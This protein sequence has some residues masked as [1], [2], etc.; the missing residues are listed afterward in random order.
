M[1]KYKT[2]LIT[3]ASSG[4]GE[5]FADALAKQGLDLILVARSKDKLDEIAARLA[6]T[7][8]RRVE[9]IAADLGQPQP[10]AALAKK[11][12]ALG[13][14]VDLLVNNAGF[15]LAGNFHKNDAARH[16][17]MVALNIGAVLDLAQ[18]FL[19]AMLE[20]GA[21]AIINVASL[22]GFQ[23][24]PYMT[25]YGATKAFVLSF[26]EGL[27]AEY[28]GKGICV[29]A[30]CPGPVDTAFF[31]ATGKGESLRK[32]VP[33]GTMLTAEQVVA[34]SLK[35]LAQGKSFVVPGALMKLASLFPRLL[36]RAAV[37]SVAART[38]KH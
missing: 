13:L 26:S 17:Q 35:A 16:T 5:T 38:M 14:S 37:A 30:V 15:G 3:G 34:A 28:R 21:G 24:T 25:V 27:W 8:D 36:P 2:A 31:E 33:P 6:K 9:V 4:I 32:T 18:T 22:A 7:Y 23:P 19:P 29:L 12:A 11:V 10:G 1:K 20:R